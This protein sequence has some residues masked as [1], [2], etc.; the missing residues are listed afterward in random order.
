MD[1]TLMEL[2]PNR[3]ARNIAIF[4]ASIQY[5]TADLGYRYIA[6]Y[7]ILLYVYC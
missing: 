7:N 5:N 2:V 6:N 1:N 3:D 4:S